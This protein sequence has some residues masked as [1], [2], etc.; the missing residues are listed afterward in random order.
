MSKA[1]KVVAAL[2]VA[3]L[4]ER[5]GRSEHKRLSAEIRHHDALY[6]DKDAPEISDAE[7]DKLRQRLK[8]IE[9]KFPQLVDLLSPTQMVAPMPTTAFAK[10]RHARPM[11]SLDNAF[12]DEELQGFLDR[13]RRALERETDLKPEDE[14]A[15]ACEPKIDGLSISLRYEDGE[16]TVGA[17]RGDG[18]TGE[19]VTANLKTIKDIPHTLKGKAPKILDVRGEVYMERHAF[20]AM[21]KRQEEAGDKSF[22]N[23]RNAAAGSLRQLDTTITAGRPLRFFAY[24]WGEA[25]PR[26]WKTH[27]EYLKLLRGWGFKVNPLS[28]LCRTPEEV[29]DFYRRMGIERPSLPYDIDGVVYKV[30]RIDWQERLGFVSRAPRWAIAHKFPAEQART[31]LNG[32]LIQVGRTGALTPVADLEP[33]NVGGVMVARASLH[34]AD[35]IERLDVRAGD[36]VVVQRAGDVIPQILGFVPEERPKKTE[37]FHFPT[38]CPCPLATPVKA[39]EGGVVRRCSGGLECPFQ[40]VERLRYFVSRNCFDIDGLGGTHIENFFNDGLLKIPGDIFRL[41]QRVDEIRKREGWGDLSVR[42][43]VAAIEARKTIAL[44]RF[45]NALGIPLIGEATAKILAQEY[46]DADTWLAE[47]LSAAK[48]RKAK[49]DDVK[50][51]KA[52]AEIGPSYGRLCNVEQIG[53]TTADAMCAFFSEG[54]NVE[55]IKDLRKQLTVEAVTRRVIAD[56]A[57]LKDKIVVFTGELSTMTREAAKARAEELGA[58]VTDSVSKKTSLVVVGENAG[59]KARKATELGVQTLT[60]EEWVKLSG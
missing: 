29:R 43:L 39:E 5:Q 28:Q 33:V 25:E 17:T 56:D 16:F 44:D 55:I 13:L 8:A 48:E 9:A 15:L 38:H 26:T 32:I 20:Q 12:T 47:M 27:T 14:I 51:E 49:P 6:H 30:D 52:T 19:D 50:K 46:G 10:V 4:T 36:M 40:Q 41:P 3:D 34:N 42:N 54:H 53:V 60:E 7:Y 22:A 24:A 1:A 57:P 45:I 58:K 21:N 2:A 35:E 11:L 37:K 23:P 59:S 18:T 31:R